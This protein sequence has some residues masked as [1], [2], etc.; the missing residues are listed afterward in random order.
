MNFLN[1]LQAFFTFSFAA[2]L[3]QI[4]LTDGVLPAVAIGM[5]SLFAIGFLYG[6]FPRVVGVLF[7]FSWLGTAHLFI[8]LMRDF[9]QAENAPLLNQA[10]LSIYFIALVCGIAANIGQIRALVSMRHGDP[11]QVGSEPN[12]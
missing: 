10:T 1:A 7:V 6:Q 8:L 9:T 11:E 2:G 3:A 12:A 4:F 5:A